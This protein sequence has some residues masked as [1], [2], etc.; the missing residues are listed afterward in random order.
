MNRTVLVR[1]NSQGYSFD[2]TEMEIEVLHKT[3]WIPLPI[4][5]DTDP[6]DVK[7]ALEDTSGDTVIIIDQ[8]EA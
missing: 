4:P 6:E 3:I 5:S 8:E 1:R 2:C 7:K